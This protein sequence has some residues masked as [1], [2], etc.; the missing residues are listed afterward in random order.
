M[1]EQIFCETLLWSAIKPCATFNQYVS[2]ASV[3]LHGTPQNSP[4]KSVVTTA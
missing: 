4:E 2:R 1:R 3:A